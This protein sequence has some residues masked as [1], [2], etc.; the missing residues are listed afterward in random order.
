MSWRRPGKLSPRNC[1]LSR[2]EAPKVRN[3]ETGEAGKRTKLIINQV[4]ACKAGLLRI[5]QGLNP[6]YRC[7][8]SITAARSCRATPFPCNVCFIEPEITRRVYPLG[9]SWASL[10]LPWPLKS[11]PLHTIEKPLTAIYLMA[12]RELISATTRWASSSVIVSTCRS[13]CS[14]SASS[15]R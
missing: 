6:P 11:F 3:G 7:N 4:N 5:A 8:S 2:N 13:I 14:N 9:S 1:S 10:R 15:A 12:S